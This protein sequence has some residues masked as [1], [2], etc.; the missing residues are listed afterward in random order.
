SLKKENPNWNITLSDK[1]EESLNTALENSKIIL[2][3]ELI[4][5]HSDLFNSFP[6]EISFDIIVSNPPYIPIEE[7]DSLMKDVIDFEPH[8]ALFLEDPSNF[9]N[10]FLIQAK[11][12]LKPGGKIYLE[13]HSEWA[14]K[15]QEISKDLLFNSCTIKKDYSEKDRMLRIEL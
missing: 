3:E 5:F 11:Q 1:S 8:E 7:K 9:F 12:R 6:P 2:G 4:H 10:L 15:I 14:K 13:V